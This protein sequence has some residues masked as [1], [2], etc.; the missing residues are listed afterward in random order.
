[1][2]ERYNSSAPSLRGLAPP[3]GGDWGS[4]LVVPQPCCDTPSVKNQRFLTAPSKREPR[5]R[6]RRRENALLFGEGGPLAVGEVRTSSDLACARPPGGELP[7][8]GKRGHPG[9]SPE[10]KAWA[11]EDVGPYIEIFKHFLI[12]SAFRCPWDGKPVPYERLPMIPEKRFLQCR[13]KYYPLP[14]RGRRRWRRN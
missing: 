14:R 8:R 7:R 4:V 1:M 10:G 5:A 2:Q 11:V 3:Q 13:R 9:V 6:L 12:G